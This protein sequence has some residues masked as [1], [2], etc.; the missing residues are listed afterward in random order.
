VERLT[1]NDNVPDW[2]A[3]R[4]NKDLFGQEA[5]EQAF[6]HALQS[7]RMPHAWLIAGRSGIGK[8]TLAFRFARFLLAGGGAEANSL[9]VADDDKVFR[10]IASSGHADLLTVERQ[11]DDEKGRQ[12][13]EI[14]VDDVRRIAP[15]LR[16]TAAEG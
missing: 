1:A 6:L 14:A 10:R 7:G 4:A 2:P 12:R 8:A 13:K 5:A 16:L 3:P 15:F 9:A 11:Y